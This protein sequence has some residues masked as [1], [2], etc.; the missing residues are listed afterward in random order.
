MR[1]NRL[2]AKIAT[3]SLY[4]MIAGSAFYL[5][6]VGIEIY[7]IYRYKSGLSTSPANYQVFLV[8]IQASRIVYSVLYIFCGISFIL[9]FTRAY[10]NLQILM[11]TS[12]FHYKPWAAVVTWFI[13][14]WNL[15]GP[16]NI[17]SNLFDK[18]ERYLVN[19][20]RMEL[21]PK[22]DIVKGWWWALWIMSAVV[23]RMSAYYIE[24]NPFSM[25]GPLA[26]L[27]GFVISIICAFFAIK[28][29][30]NYREMEVLI[31]SSDGSTIDYH[32]SNDDLL[33]SGI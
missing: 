18:T 7:I 2:R 12:K 24:G 3:I 15:F 13:P 11:P 23:I 8:L 1:P 28:M 27:V 16:Y 30:R 33:D 20:E 32:L 9:W 10:R 26:T 31:L 21:R 29:I 6:S 25:I 5:F 22:Y 4:T 14:V 19:E 17:A